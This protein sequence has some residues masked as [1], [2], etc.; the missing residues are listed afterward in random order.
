MHENVKFLPFSK[1]P[2][3]FPSR[4]ISSKCSLDWA[5]FTVKKIYQYVEDMFLC[6]VEKIPIFTDPLDQ[7][8][9]PCVFEYPSSKVSKK[10][11]SLSTE[12]VVISPIFPHWSPIILGLLHTE[13]FKDHLNSRPLPW[14]EIQRPNTPTKLKVFSKNPAKM[15]VYP[16]LRELLIYTYLWNNRLNLMYFSTRWIPSA[17]S[18][19][20]SN[21]IHS[22]E[23]Y[24]NYSVK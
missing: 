13:V 5:I 22:V 20:V 7:P 18:S 24:R 11:S 15:L 23:M 12:K 19:D 2:C 10:S 14:N 21:I 6:V 8:V 9:Y 16:C 1:N 17:Q 4:Y 3:F